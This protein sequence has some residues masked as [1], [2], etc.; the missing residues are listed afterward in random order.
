M[1]RTDS[2]RRNEPIPSRNASPSE[3]SDKPGVEPESWRDLMEF[4]DRFSDDAVFGILTDPD[5]GPEG[6]W[7]VRDVSKVRPSAVP[8]DQATTFDLAV[9]GP[10]AKVTCEV[11]FTIDQIEH[12]RAAEP[13]LTCPEGDDE[14]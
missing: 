1:D 10:D 9:L 6:F 13:P 11:R 7:I 2:S 12:V 4:I 5:N 3:G 14:A 8:V